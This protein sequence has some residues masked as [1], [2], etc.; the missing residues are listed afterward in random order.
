MEDKKI[1]LIFYAAVFLFSG[2]LYA[3]ESSSASQPGYYLD[4]STGKPVFK[5]RLAWDKEE[6]A[7]YYEVEIQIFSG[8][9]YSAYYSETTENT[10]IETSLSPG[11][12]RYS[13]TPYDLLRRRGD[14]SDWEEF[15]INTAYQPE[16]VKIVPS[17]FYMDQSKERVLLISG[18]NIFDDSVIYLRNGARDLI[19]INKTITNNSSARLTFDDDTLVP[20]TYE[21]YIKNPGGLE[22]LY[23]GFFVGYQKRSETFLKIGWN[24]VIPVGGELNEIFRSYIY[25]SG[26]TFRLE[27]LSSERSSFKAGM[28]F[29]VSIYNLH[30]DDALKP[31]FDPG[32]LNVIESNASASLLD[33]SINISMQRRFNHLRNAITFY[34]GFGLTNYTT[35]GFLVSD[36]Y[37]SGNDGIDYDYYKQFDDYKTYD[38]DEVNGHVNLGI[39]GLFL[40]YKDLYIEPGVEFTYYLTGKSILIKPRIALA[41]KI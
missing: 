41:L 6:Y 16:I 40:L 28:E 3:Q 31:G 34:F 27:G 38:H 14:S 11:R 10:F 20:G 30:I 22:T 9:Q 33:L 1:I 21:I 15:T 7:L 12:Y 4:K 8:R 39:S 2:L 18:N 5:Q 23:G 32:S 29:A 25:T 26:W 37:D 36:Y 17:Y 19:P 13:V 24:P 35:S